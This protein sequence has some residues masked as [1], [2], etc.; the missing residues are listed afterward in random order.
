MSNTHKILVNSLY[1]IML[2]KPERFKNFEIVTTRKQADFQVKKTNF[3]SR[4]IVL[5]NLSILEMGKTSVIYNSPTLIGSIILQNSK[6]RMYEYLY[7]IYPKLFEI[8]NITTPTT[9]TIPKEVF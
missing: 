5:E 6:V 1:G 3:I 8:D 7:E 4:N 2:L 9:K